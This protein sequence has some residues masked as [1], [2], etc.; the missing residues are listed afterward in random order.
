MLLSTCGMATATTNSGGHCPRLGPQHG[1]MRRGVPKGA[2][3]C[4]MLT[5]AT[6]GSVVF[7]DGAVTG[8]LVGKEMEE[9]ESVC[10]CVWGVIT[11]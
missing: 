4:Y 2:I 8:G 6:G 5:I 3:D 7:L 9:K 11:G 1:I 10:V